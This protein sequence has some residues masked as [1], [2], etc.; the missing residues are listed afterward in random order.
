M[1]IHTVILAAGLGTRMKSSAPKVLHSIL[2]KPMI[3]YVMES[4]P[5]DSPIVIV[6]A[7]HSVAIED[8]INSRKISLSYQQRQLGTAD[9]LKDGINKINTKFDFLLVLNGDTPLIKKRTLKKLIKSHIKSEN[10]ITVLSFITT[11]PTA[12]GRI[13][14]DNSRVKCIIE[15]KD[16]TKK[17]KDIKEVN[18]GIYAF[19]HSTLKY[20]RYI[21]KNKKKGEYYLTD[22]ISICYE[23]GH[24]IGALCID[25]EDEFIGIN[26]RHDLH[27]AQK[28]LQAQINRT[29]MEKGVTLMDAESTFIH[30]DVKIGRDT[31]IYPNVF[32]E[33]KTRIGE[34]CIINSNVRIINSIVEDRVNI[35]DSTLIEHSKILSFS[36]IGPFAHIR[37]D[38]KIGPSSRIGNFVEVKKSI[39]GGNTKANHLSYIGDAELGRDINIGAGTITCNYDGVKKHRSIIKDGVFIGSNTQLVAPVTI[40]KGATIAAGS[41]ITKDVPENSLALTRVKQKNIKRW[42]KKKDPRG[43]IR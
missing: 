10:D 26:S 5:E 23:K 30:P 8:L 3:S 1:K 35:K 33:G 28:L 2:G 36:I 31:V 21:R 27:K 37:P 32:L 29:W 38:S 16:A 15:E 34:G 17:E 20:L 6:I 13:I 14:R 18:S 24:K 25:D 9:A 43:Q 19:N 11:N 12:Y 41:T 40:N 39:I 22:M 4:V 7:K 42:A